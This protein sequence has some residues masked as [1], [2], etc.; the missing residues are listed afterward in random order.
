VNGL[1]EFLKKI[2]PNTSV[3][4]AQGLPASPTPRP[5]NLSAEKLAAR[6]T[7]TPR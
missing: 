4:A 2:L 7:P 6:V 3:E 5:E 1:I